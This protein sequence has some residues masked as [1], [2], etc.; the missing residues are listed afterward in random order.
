MDSDRI[1]VMDDGR[2]AEFDSP[3]ALLARE[4]SIFASMVNITG[5]SSAAVLREMVRTP[6]AA[7]A[8]S[9]YTPP[10]PAPSSP[11]VVG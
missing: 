8:A 2:I 9:G 7:A 10:L 6:E 1:L 4:G 3:A 11:A 5:A